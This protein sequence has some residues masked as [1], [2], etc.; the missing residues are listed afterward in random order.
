LASE[1]W[2]ASLNSIIHRGDAEGA[3]KTTPIHR[4]GAKGAKEIVKLKNHHHPGT[5]RDPGTWLFL[6]SNLL[7]SRCPDASTVNQ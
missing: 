1:T 7:F 5:G 6:E 4:N 2:Q 3:E